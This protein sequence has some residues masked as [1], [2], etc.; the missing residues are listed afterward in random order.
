MKNFMNAIFSWILVGVLS[1]VIQAAIEKQKLTIT[2][3]GT[4]SILGPVLAGVVIIHHIKENI[5]GDFCVMNCEEKD[6]QRK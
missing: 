3:L 4:A 6:G 5:N 2:D 1:A